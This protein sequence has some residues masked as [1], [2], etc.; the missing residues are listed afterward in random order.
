MGNLRPTRRHC[1]SPSRGL[2]ATT[3]PSIFINQ[4]T[5]TRIDRTLGLPHNDHVLIVRKPLR[6]YRASIRIRTTTDIDANSM[7]SAQPARLA[8]TRQSRSYNDRSLSLSLSLSLFLVTLKGIR[9]YDIFIPIASVVICF[10]VVKY[11]LKRIIN[12]E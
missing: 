1:R 8:F 2:D 12:I 5:M 9:F 11:F 3:R 4:S 7:E 6:D 10:L